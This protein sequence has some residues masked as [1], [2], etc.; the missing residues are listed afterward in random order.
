MGRD[1]RRDGEGRGGERREGRGGKGEEGREGEKRANILH[2]SPPPSL[3]GMFILLTL[4][5]SFRLL[6]EHWQIPSGPTP[7]QKETSFLS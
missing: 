3:D 2:D 7:N 1:E 6:W 5:G 4:S